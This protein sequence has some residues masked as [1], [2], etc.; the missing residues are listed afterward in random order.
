[1]GGGVCRG[2]ALK[3]H[4]NFANNFRNHLNPEQKDP[5]ATVP[6]EGRA[7]WICQWAI[8][9]QMCEL[10]GFNRAIAHKNDEQEDIDVLVTE[11]QLGGPSTS[12]LPSTPKSWYNPAIG[13]T[14]IHHA[15]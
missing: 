13:A 10:K 3:E 14:F 1:M 6:K 4:N 11:E 5:Y 2:P 7:L 9:P 8:D 12:T 15:N